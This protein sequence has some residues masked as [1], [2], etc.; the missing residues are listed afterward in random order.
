MN[1]KLNN[2][3]VPHEALQCK[4]YSCSDHLKEINEFCNDIIN[5]CLSAGSESL[6]MTGKS[7]NASHKSNTKPGWNEYCK[8][9][10]EIA[11][12]WHHQW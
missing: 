1:I 10:K 12:Y 11:L 4:L 6:P 7:A 2:L 8:D 3:K 9:K 5:V